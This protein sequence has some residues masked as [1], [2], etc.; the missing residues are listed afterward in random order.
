MQSYTNFFITCPKG[1]EDLLA[2]ECAVAGITELTMVTGGIEFQAE[3][4]QAYHLCLWSRLASRV[5]LRLSDFEAD[6]YDDLY[7]AVKAIDWSQHMDASSCFAIDCFTAHTEINNSH[8]ATLR[9][10]DAVVDQFTENAGVRPDVER[11]TPDIRINVYLGKQQAAIYLD[12][13]G[14]PLHIRGYRQV[15]G[16]APLKENLAAAILLRCK[17]PALAA[18]QKTLYDPM[19]GS[20]SL[21][22]EAAYIALN[23]APGIMRHYYGFYGWKQHSRE[24]WQ[25]I[26]DQAEAGELALDTLPTFIGCDVSASTITQ[27]EK[28]IR[29]AGLKNQIELRVVDSLQTSPE[30]PPGTGLVLTNPPYGKRLGDVRELK[31]LYYRLGHMLKHEFAGWEAAVFTAEDELAKT[32]GLR[33]HHKNTL[34]NGALKCTL[35]QYHLH[36]LQSPVS[37]DSSLDKPPPAV[38]EVVAKSRSENAAMFENRLRKNLKHLSKWA[39]RQNLNCY[40]LYDA[41]LPQYALAIDVYGKQAH[42]QEYKAPVE[43]DSFKVEQR[44]HEAIE[45]IAEVLSLPAQ[46]IVLKTRQKQSGNEQYLRQDETGRTRIVD[47]HG[48]KFV[49]NLHDYLDTG[50]FLDHRPMRQLIRNISRDK[51]FLNLFAYTGSVSVAAAAGGASSTT[52]VD[53]SNTYLDWAQDNMALNNFSG[54]E[55]LFERADCNQ[56]LWDAWKARRSFQL[57]FL[58][59]PTF[60][61]S[62]KMQSTF[63]VVRDHV[64]LIEHT[65]RLL[66]DDGMLIFST[67]ARSFKLA[68]TSLAAYQIEDL[69]ALTTSEDFRRRPAHRCWCISRHSVDVRWAELMR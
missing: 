38:A 1:V 40:R 37:A 15:G 26:L 52:T 31:S 59:P 57:V 27:A 28:N 4:A 45:V 32:I 16:E 60:S 63:D 17:W 44:L 20:A 53:M 22:I 13:S 66:D 34:Y 68:A 67:N 47:E 54:G 58:D 9:I 3:I 6:D 8:F 41:D 69:T 7:A 49:I 11:D 21:L 19:C 51:S 33:A 62:K 10:K 65:M 48:L 2:Q 36:A 56:W 64:E 30:L 50:L 12:L 14:Q 55:N 43:I 25:S 24:L 42:V 35:Y 5:L 18:Q 46:A 61:N 29:A 23:R 39:R